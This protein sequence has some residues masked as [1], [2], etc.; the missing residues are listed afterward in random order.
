MLLM[1]TINELPQEHLGGVMQI[2]REAASVDAEED[3]I[4]LEIDQ[5]DVKTQRKLLRHVSKVRSSFW[6]CDVL[7]SS[8]V[9]DLV[10]E[11]A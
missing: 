10:C 3:E 4:D 5:L 2:I 9:S 7:F 6:Y 11:E 1:D 8:S